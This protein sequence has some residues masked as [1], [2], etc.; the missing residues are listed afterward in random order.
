MIGGGTG[1][2]LP[3]T[4]GVVQ[5]SILV[6]VLFLMFTN[7][8]SQHVAHGKLVMYA[9]DAHFWDAESPGNLPELKKRAEETISAAPLWF[10]KKRLK[11]SPTK[12]E[13]HVLN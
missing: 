8:L 13:L 3:V 7:D 6:H 4:H 11:I 10:T 12:T 9:D 2:N 1:K 5:G